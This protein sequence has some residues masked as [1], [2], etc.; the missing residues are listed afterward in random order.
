MARKILETQ[1]NYVVHK[2]NLERARR[3]LAQ[4]KAAR[5]SDTE[6]AAAQAR[7]DYCKEKNRVALEA[8]NLRGDSKTSIG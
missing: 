2:S 3:T 7:V 5:A 8:I 1:L 4:L 6:I